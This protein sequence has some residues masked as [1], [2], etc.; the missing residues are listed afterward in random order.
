MQI[1]AR[2]ALQA[3]T[4]V[5]VGAMLIFH[6]SVLGAQ[7]FVS[8]DQ[9]VFGPHRWWNSEVPAHIASTRAAYREFGARGLFAGAAWTV[10]GSGYL[11]DPEHPIFLNLWV[12]MPL[13]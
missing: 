7:A 11:A 8:P 3:A 9:S 10:G 1:S 12:Q 5:L 4:G 2:V 13:R 6:F